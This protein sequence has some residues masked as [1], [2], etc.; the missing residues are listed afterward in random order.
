MS[1][2]LELSS[3]MTGSTDAGPRQ[4]QKDIS[5]VLARSSPF[6]LHPAPESPS[7]R[8]HRQRPPRKMTLTSA[9]GQP[10]QLTP[11]WEHVVRTRKFPIEVDTRLTFLEIAERLRDP[12][13]EVRQHALRVLID[14]LPTLSADVVDKV[15]QPVVPELVNNLGHPAPAVRKGALDALRVFLIHSRDRENTIRKILQDGLNRS[16]IHDSFQTNV[17]TG[18][19]L[20][21]PSL[22]FPSSSSPSPDVRL[23]KD[24]TVA[25]ASRLAQVP[26][27]E[28]VLKSLTKICD[29][30]GT[31]EF[32]SYLEDYD[33]KLKRNIQVLSKIYNIKSARK[34][35]KKG[36]D[37]KNLTKGKDSERKWDS[38]SDTSGIAEEEDEVSS[39]AM[40]AARVVL[41]TEIKFNEETAITMTILEEKEDSEKEQDEESGTD[42][43]NDGDGKDSSSP[44]R[45][46][47]PRRVHF[48]GEVVKLRTPD[49]DETESVEAAPKTRIPVPVSPARK[50]PVTR[51]RPSSQPC[52]PRRELGKLRRASRSV[53]SSPKREVYTHNAELSPKKSILARTSSPMLASRPVEQVKRRKSSGKLEERGKE[54]SRGEQSSESG[55]DVENSSRGI[56][57]AG[58][59]EEVKR[60]DVKLIQNIATSAANNFDVEDKSLKTA[61]ENR[62]KK[63]TPEAAASKVS[64]R[65]DAESFSEVRSAKEAKEERN[66]SSRERRSGAEVRTLESIPR[67]IVGEENPPS[68]DSLFGSPVKNDEV[69]PHRAI[70]SSN[71]EERP[72]TKESKDAEN[73]ALGRETTGKLRSFETKRHSN[74]DREALRNDDG[75]RSSRSGRDKAGVIEKNGNAASE[76]GIVEEEPSWEELGL[77]DQEVLEDLHN[78]EDWRARVRGLERVASALRTSSAL[79]AIEPRLGSL[80][81]AVLGCE[82]SCR[83]AAA[84]LAVA[85]V[86][87]AGVSEEALKKR[88]PQLA[89]GLAR[90]GGPSAAQ[91]ARVTMLRLRPALLLEQLLQ[92]HCLNARNAKTRENTLQLLIFS[93]VT[94][95]STE[96]K[97]DTVANKVAKMVR[98]RRRRVRQA[99]LDT[100]AVLAQI[101]ESEEVLAAGKRASE[102]HHDGEAMISAIR[103]R[104][105]RKSLP[106]VSADGLVMY[107]LQISPAVQIATGPDV[108][109]IV[110]GSGSVSPG[111][112]RTKG[113]I[114]ATRSEKGQLARDENASSYENPWIERPNLVALGMGIRPKIDQPVV[115]Q[116][117]PTQRQDMQCENETNPPASRGA[118]VDIRNGEGSASGFNVKSR[119]Q[120][121]I[122]AA[123][124]ESTNYRNIVEDNFEQREMG[125]KVESRIPVLFARDRGPKNPEQDKF[126]LESINANSRRRYRDATENT[127][128]SNF[129]EE[130]VR[131][132][133]TIYRRKK[134]QQENSTSMHYDTYRP[135]KNSTNASAEYNDVL[136][137]TSEEFSDT[138]ARVYQKYSEMDRF[139]R[140]PDMRSRCRSNSVES[141]QTLL[142]RS[143]QQQ[144]FIM[145]DM[146]N[147]AARRE[148]RFVDENSF[149]PLQTA[150]TLLTHAY[151]KI[152]FNQRSGENHEG[153]MSSRAR[154][155]RRTKDAA[156][157]KINDVEMMSSDA[158]TNEHFPA[159]CSGTPYR[160]RLRSLSPSQLYHRQ[161]FL[162]MAPNEVHA[163]SMYDV[164]KAVSEEEYNEKNKHHFLPE[165]SYR[166]HSPSS[167]E[168]RF[169]AVLDDHELSSSDPLENNCQHGIEHDARDT[170]DESDSRSSSPDR[171]NVDSAFDVITGQSS[172]P[173]QD[174]VDFV[175]SLNPKVE[176]PAEPAVASI[177]DDASKG[178][179]SE[180]EAKSRDQ[181]RA[182]SRNSEHSELRE[183]NA[184]ESESSASDE[185][186]RT[187]ERS[188][189]GRRS[190]VS[191]LTNEDLP[192]SDDALNSDSPEV[193]PS[194]SRRSSSPKK[195]SRSP[196][197][198]SIEFEALKSPR[199]DSRGSSHKLSF[200]LE[201]KESTDSSEERP[202]SSIAHC[203]NESFELVEPSQSRRG[204]KTTE[205][206]T[207]IIASRP[208]SSEVPAYVEDHVQTVTQ[209]IEN[210]DDN[211]HRFISESNGSNN[212]EDGQSKDSSSE[213][214]TEPAILKIETEPVEPPS[215]PKRATSKVP[216][217][218]RRH[219]GNVSKVAPEKPEKLK[220]IVQQCF[221]QL[222]SK[223]W[224]ITMKGLK[225]LSEIAKQQPEYL[226]VCAAATI[227][228]LLGQQVKSLRSQVARAACLAAGDVFSS[229][230]RGIDQDFDDIAG[231][232][233]HRTADTNRFLRADSNAALDLM[234]EHLPPHKTISVIFL[235]GASH[236]NAIVRAAT[237]RLLASIVDQ[238]G[239]EHTL[240]LPKDVRE[241]LLNT[242]ARLLIDG[243]LD[244]RNHAK[245]MFRSLAGCEG[246]RKALTDAVPETTLRHIDKTLKTL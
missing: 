168:T 162:R 50:M 16:E 245:R 138:G 180:E 132:S 113:Q 204:S 60:E 196:S 157:Q 135:I 88:L 95:P 85:K 48:G 137:S 41:E 243:N 216:R 242:G 126:T 160:R 105:A 119:N 219:R 129:Q 1:E 86:V 52:S 96:F 118:S 83:V 101:Y 190:A 145:H 45:R 111:I 21:V 25:L 82:R 93:L 172:P 26:H 195:L 184:N 203:D 35:P 5:P 217:V 146:Y 139:S 89:W 15:M 24:A 181:S 65:A 53:S 87:V 22:L 200:D 32:E 246:F 75:E 7:R 18:V 143:S 37:A 209:S 11:L 125:D 210:D 192:A 102:G 108:D 99:A 167:T 158:Q 218:T 211:G 63:E 46:K 193:Q 84:G 47:T 90:Q 124:K 76:A 197:R 61:K 171:P 229:Q 221:A 23:V 227:S 107:G 194:P 123:V 201:N 57:I 72:L 131:S 79:I 169:D 110:A 17:T 174:T 224:E 148:G 136:E 186:G 232:L 8:G 179:S 213:T 183:E 34:S 91:L 115:W 241:K 141:H 38:D 78:K 55:K 12:E 39:N 233:L 40:P 30:V 130:S 33:N 155:Y 208:H 226:D 28:A 237:A 109:W 112:G 128:R 127:N 54:I 103:A 69:Q 212:L 156:A 68:D 214:N 176:S 9:N 220:P 121:K 165:E 49:S 66:Q 166:V 152:D 236:Q 44:D 228:R 142:P 71:D 189:A 215:L 19:I 199:R 230:I 70:I 122:P 188:S 206:P 150:P 59:T 178:W 144:T 207:I 153:S 56:A 187:E 104:L 240:M 239:P 120:A 231:P 147:A 77:V 6:D 94:F 98:D 175:I 92:A 51:T 36:E 42:V 10:I 177:E 14:V 198:S 164:D 3:S 202:A 106:L 191:V 234:I 4:P 225:T 81:H 222:E 159:I 163:M 20:S 29:A 238:I 133:G 173:H 31:E 182:S 67:K 235:R 161:Q 58:R 62:E 43:R 244:A 223:E 64:S 185:I 80:L 205:S 114:I 13:W 154:F 151:N 134:N 117:V 170:Q 2:W 74:V 100:L 140:K 116:M 73:E 149:R 97:V 27:Q